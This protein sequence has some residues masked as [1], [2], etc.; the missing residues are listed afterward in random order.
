MAKNEK[1]KLK[2]D[3]DDEN[4]KNEEIKISKKIKMQTKKESRIPY[5]ERRKLVLEQLTKP[6]NPS[7]SNFS[8]NNIK[9]FD[10]EKIREAKEK[11]IQREI[12]KIKDSKMTY[13]EKRLKV[14]NKLFFSDEFK[15]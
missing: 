10:I 2:I 3:N 4:L 11:Y 1:M 14:L 9:L 13:D 5:R 6:N 15:L 12:E 8:N 7:Y